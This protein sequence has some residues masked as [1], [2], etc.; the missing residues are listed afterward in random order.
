MAPG[1]SANEMLWTLVNEIPAQC[2]KQTTSYSMDSGPSTSVIDADE[3]PA[4]GWK[5]LITASAAYKYAGGFRRRN[6]KACLMPV[7]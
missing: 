4:P 3:L 5:D 2:E 1:T 6:T 7:A